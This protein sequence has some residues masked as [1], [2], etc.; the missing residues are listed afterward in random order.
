MANNRIY[1]KCN[2]CGEKLFLGKCGQGEYYWINYDKE[3]G[4]PNSPTLEDRL[5][6]FYEKHCFCKEGFGNGDYSIE[7]Q[8]P[9]DEA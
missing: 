8:F 6:M 2:A 9:I 7:Y 1:L 3:N 4:D 5:N